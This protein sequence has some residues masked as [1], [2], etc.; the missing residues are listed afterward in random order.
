MIRYKLV[1]LSDKS[2]DRT[3]FDMVSNDGSTKSVSVKD[4]FAHT[5]GCVLRY[6]EL[7]CLGARGKNS[8][9][10]FPVEMCYINPGQH[11]KKKVIH[12]LNV[13]GVRELHPRLYNSEHVPISYFITVAQ[14][15]TSIGHDQVDSY[16]A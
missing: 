5:Y 15:R 1:K 10:F 14:R 7:P 16:Q 3:Y 13:V 2:A 4:Y 9:S 6:P 12:S 8:I 11:Y